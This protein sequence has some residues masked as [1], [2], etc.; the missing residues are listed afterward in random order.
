MGRVMANVKN[1]PLLDTLRQRGK[2]SVNQYGA[3]LSFDMNL[4]APPQTE[5][6]ILSPEVALAAEKMVRSPT[7]KMPDISQL[8]FPYPQMAIEIPLTED[9]KK[10]RENVTEGMFPV[11]RI[12]IFIQSSQEHGWVNCSTYW[13]YEDGRMEPPLF[14]FSL[15]M[16]D[17][18]VPEIRMATPQNPTE[19]VNFKALPST[20]VIDA[21]MR[22]NIPPERLAGLFT[23]PD[24][25]T[26]IKESVSELPLLLFAC[27]LMIN[28]KTG[29]KRTSVAARTPP[30]RLSLGAKKKKKYSSSRYTILHLEEI[31]TVGIDGSISLRADVAAHYV[32][33]HF[34]NR[35]SGLYWW[36]PFVRG[37]GDPAKRVAYLTKDTND[38]QVVV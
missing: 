23:H 24:S 7:F 8:R 6:F 26:A 5:I 29:V 25:S 15:G 37:K 31:E 14:S 16:D 18:P 13:G 9:I 35:Q 10:L 32:R 22:A 4:L 30:A 1:K 17:L 27:T 2:I 3:S 33:G 38:N 20:C 11:D 21:F 28:C 19:T 12:G 34:K 36:N